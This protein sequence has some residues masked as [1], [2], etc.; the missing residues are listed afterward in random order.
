MSTSHLKSSNRSHREALSV[1]FFK[2]VFT[3]HAFT[4]IIL[5]PVPPVIAM[6]AASACFAF[7]CPVVCVPVSVSN[8]WRRDPADYKARRVG[9][10]RMSTD[11][12]LPPRPLWPSISSARESSSA[13]ENVNT[14]R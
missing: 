13:Q 8:P 1:V 4:K 2:V 14:D 10:L 6:L 9:E 5:P 3:P 12:D 7:R 11:S